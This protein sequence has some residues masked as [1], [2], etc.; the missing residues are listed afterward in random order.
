MKRQPYEKPILIVIAGPNGTGK[1]SFSLQIRSHR[2][3]QDCIFI[4]PDEIALKK[5]GDWNSHDAVLKAAKYAERVREKY[6][7]RQQS[8]AFETVFSSLPKVDYVKRAIK[9]DFFVRFFFIGTDSPTI[10][11]N[12]I[13]RR[14]AEGGHSVPLQKIFSRYTKSLTNLAHILQVLHRGYI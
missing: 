10:N 9:A 8:L 6:L 3:Y 7:Q 1:T 12:R 14:V 5:Y 4:N 11:V 13:G 2:W